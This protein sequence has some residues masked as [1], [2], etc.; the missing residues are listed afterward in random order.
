MSEKRKI[1]P[2]E[3]YHVYNRGVLKMRLFREPADYMRLMLKI[4]L[5]KKRYPVQIMAYCLMPNH[6]HLL[7]RELGTAPG[8]K[9]NI[10][11]F[12]QQLQGGYAKYFGLKYKHSG[13]VFQGVFKAK[14]IKDDGQ[15]CQTIKY[16]ENN[17]VRKKMVKSAD[18][19]PY[20]SASNPNI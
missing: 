11:L 6:F 13:C 10:S 16:I 3:I 1:I 8:K 14:H 4:S 18:K 20:S 19:W 5:L 17:P 12:M 2:N 7:L 9:R 15:L